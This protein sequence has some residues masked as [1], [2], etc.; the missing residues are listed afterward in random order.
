MKCGRKV[1]EHTHHPLKQ[2]ISYYYYLHPIHSTIRCI[3][4]YHSNFDNSD[5]AQI[6]I[7]THTHICISSYKFG[8]KS[9]KLL[10]DDWKNLTRQSE[11]L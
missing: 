3:Y 4:Y 5:E 8:G 9:L 1:N 7:H 10:Y 6:A 11:T 2:V